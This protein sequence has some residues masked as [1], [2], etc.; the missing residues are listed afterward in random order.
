MCDEFLIDSGKT[1]VHPPTGDEKQ[2]LLNRLRR[3]EGQVRGIQ[4]MVDDD[5]YCVDILVQLSA[6]NQALKKVGYSLLERHSH[7]CVTAAVESGN[8]EEAIEELMKVF[9]QFS[10]S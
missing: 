2:Q 5:R 10:K 3:V 6:V 4:K 7:H 9:Q 1:P 8:G